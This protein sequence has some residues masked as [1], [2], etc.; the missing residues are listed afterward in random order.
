MKPDSY[1]IQEIF[2]DV[3]DSHKLYIQ[4]WGNPKA[5]TPIIFLH[6]GPGDGTSDRVKSRF[7][8]EHQRLIFFDQRGSGNSLPY[9]ELKFNT[10]TD[11]ISDINKIADKLKLDKFIISG[12]S[13]GSLLS[14]AY[15]LE[16]PE[17]LI[18]V[19]VSGVFLG[20]RNE[21]DWIAEGGFKNF[22]PEAWDKLLAQTPKQD[23]ASPLDYH[24]EQVKSNEFELAKKSAFV[25]HSL[26]GS[27]L[28]LDDR[29]MRDDY[30]KYD[31]TAAFIAVH[32][33]S[34]NCFI[35]DNYILNNAK[36]INL[37]VRIIQ[38]RY[39]MVSP[40]ITAYLLNERL[41][42]SRL[43]WSINGHIGE[44]EAANIMKLAYLELSGEL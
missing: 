29:P 21:L 7:D 14:L 5:K 19:V 22:Y 37:P 15:A 32:Y 16:H 30:S 44:H 38:G 24:F 34:N 43:S 31:P 42:N 20:S 18:G 12:N 36:N 6:G 10:T 28:R 17:R 3:G 27:L 23:Q 11:L 26:E 1:T 4:E 40:P 2:L 35:E 9:G 25:Y 33:M 39:D 8:P 13:W 41:P